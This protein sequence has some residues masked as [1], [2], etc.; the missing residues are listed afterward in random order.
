MEA[1]DELEKSVA[2]QDFS[3][4]SLLKEK[5]MELESIKRDLLKEAEEP[6]TKET[7]VEKVLICFD[8]VVVKRYFSLY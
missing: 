4:A 2:L 5:I 8:L 7:R 3:L 6:Q 1:K